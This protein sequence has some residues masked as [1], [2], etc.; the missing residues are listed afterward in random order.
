[1]TLKS[2]RAIIGMTNLPTDDRKDD[3]PMKPFSVRMPANLVEDVSRKAGTIP[4][5]VIIRRLLE[6]W[7]KGE[8]SID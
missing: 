2:F 5:A 6:K 4:L 1:M 3:E 7:L 8:V